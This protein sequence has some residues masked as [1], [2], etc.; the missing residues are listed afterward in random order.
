MFVC[1]AQDSRFDPQHLQTGSW[2][3]GPS[4]TLTTTNRKRQWLT[5]C[6][7]WASRGQQLHFQFIIDLAR[8]MFLRPFTSSKYPS[9]QRRVSP[10]RISL[11]SQCGSQT[12]WRQWGLFN[13]GGRSQA[14]WA[15]L[16]SELFSL[17]CGISE[18]VSL[19][20]PVHCSTVRVPRC[21]PLAALGQLVAMDSHRC[22]PIQSCKFTSKQNKTARKSP[23]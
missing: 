8:Q 16:S 23:F 3:P 21:A 6:T 19:L 4:G 11:R 5:Q 20:N 12:R 13:L 18:W 15:K 1:H 17:L 10:D 14:F 9:Q 22:R 2:I 7:Q